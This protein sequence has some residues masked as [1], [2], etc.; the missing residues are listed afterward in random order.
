MF[1]IQGLDIE[2]GDTV[3]VPM[4]VTE[5]V[6]GTVVKVT[7]VKVHVTAPTDP[8]KGYGVDGSWYPTAV[9]VI[10]KPI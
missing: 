1:D 10:N 7:K 8:E 2:V 3:V 9:L 4:K 5:L 6:I